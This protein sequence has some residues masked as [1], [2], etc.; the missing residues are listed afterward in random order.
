MSN[1]LHY[2]KLALRDLDEIWEYVFIDSYS[3]DIAGNV[4]NE[5]LNTVEYLE[6][7][8]EMGTELDKLVPFQS[9]YR[10]LVAGTYLV[11]YRIVNS[12]IYIDRIIHS[13]RNYIR[14]LFGDI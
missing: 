12:D 13:K 2:S 11:F 8:A 6:D 3:L 10:M 9:D 4:I 5:I 1:I 14:I 7:F